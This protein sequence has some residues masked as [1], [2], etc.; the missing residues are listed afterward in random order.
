MLYRSLLG[1]P[2]Y[3]SNEALSVQDKLVSHRKKL[4]SCS[5]DS[6]SKVGLVGFLVKIL[7]FQFCSFKNEHNFEH[8]ETSL[9]A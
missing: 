8:N 7:Q 1:S 2:C 6:K 3:F 4:P 9:Q 5:T